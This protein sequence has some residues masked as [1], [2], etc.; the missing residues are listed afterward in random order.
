MPRTITIIDN[1]NETWIKNL[2]SLY[3]FRELL[4]IL[5]GKEIQLR[6]R[7]TILGLSWVILQPI[8]TSLIFTFI[9]G[10][11]MKAPSDDQQYIL[12]AFVGLI[13]WNSFAQSVQRCGIS[14]IKDL[15]LITKI[16]FP[17]ILIPVSNI[18]AAYVD[19]MISLVILAALM[20]FFK[21][22]F[23]GTLFTIPFF[24]VLSIILSAAVGLIFA[25][26]NVFY[27]DITMILPFV[28]QAWM[29]ASPVAYSSKL[30]PPQWLWIYSLNPLTGLIDGFRWAV[31]AS[32]P[33]P[34]QSIFFTLLIT[35]LASIGSLVLFGRLER[36]F[37]DVI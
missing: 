8:I 37:A 28:L 31:F 18:L 9:F 12:F 6:Y 30:I 21:I 36:K 2:R 35:L 34:Y 4:M 3:E 20:L 27:R 11:L 16:F 29:F 22:P 10:V 7:Q 15:R 24:L 19:L 1:S 33:F 25:S 32:T 14:L 13:V 26:L 5:T 17:R 23:R